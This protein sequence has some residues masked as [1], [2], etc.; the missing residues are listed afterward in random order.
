MDQIEYVSIKQPHPL[1]KKMIIR[2]QLNEQ[3]EVNENDGN[4]RYLFNKAL[5]TVKDNL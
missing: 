1:E 4:V 2:V 3:Q 5:M